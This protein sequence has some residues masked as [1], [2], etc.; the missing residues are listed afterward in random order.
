MVLRM[1][2]RHILGEMC[3]DVMHGSIEES[4]HCPILEGGG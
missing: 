1:H 4:H 3:L 2:G